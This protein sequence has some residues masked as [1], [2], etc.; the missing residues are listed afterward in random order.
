MKT[1]PHL[2]KTKGVRACVP[3]CVP[4]S[5]RLLPPLPLQTYLLQVPVIISRECRGTTP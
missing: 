2:V 5:V 4:V 1:A 3:V